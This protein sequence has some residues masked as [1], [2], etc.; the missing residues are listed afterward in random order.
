MLKSSLAWPQIVE[1]QLDIEWD[2]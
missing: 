1:M 2:I